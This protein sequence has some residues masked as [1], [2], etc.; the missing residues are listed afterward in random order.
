MIEYENYLKIKLKYNGPSNEII[1]DFM[2]RIDL[3]VWVYLLALNE[4]KIQELALVYNDP[5]AIDFPFWNKSLTKYASSKFLW[6]LKLAP[7]YA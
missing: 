5:L 2:M 1:Q 4:L 6:Q 7:E 3:A